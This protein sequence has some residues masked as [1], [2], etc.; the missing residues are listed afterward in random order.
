LL[1]VPEPEPEDE[2]EETHEPLPEQ[3]LAY[4]TPGP[5][6][7]LPT[8]IPSEPVVAPTNELVATL[9][10]AAS[11]PAT[12]DE[13]PTPVEEPVE[14]DLVVVSTPTP[15]PL[16]VVAHSATA[17][18]GRG[19]ARKGARRRSSGGSW[20]ILMAVTAFLIL[21]GGAWF[22]YQATLPDVPDVIT[23]ERYRSIG[24]PPAKF[25]APSSGAIADEVREPV[26]TSL[27]SEGLP[28]KSG[29]VEVWL[30][31]EGDE[32]VVEVSPGPRS[33]VVRVPLGELA[34]IRSTLSRE[35][36]HIASIKSRELRR[37]TADFFRDYAEYLKEGTAVSRFP[38]YRDDV[39]LN[40]ATGVTGY[41]VEAVVGSTPFL[42][43]Y[44]DSTGGCYFFP[45][46][47]TQKFRIRGRKLADGTTPLPIEIDV[48]V[49]NAEGATPSVEE[50]V[51]EQASPEDS[52]S[53]ASDKADAA[54]VKGNEAKEP[55][56]RDE[57][58]MSPDSET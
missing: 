38:E 42:C 28:L 20:S 37:S 51:P 33:N 35:R 1:L 39:A 16:P 47:E 52:E 19:A 23:G 14:E 45:P 8:A 21:A 49:K 55:A 54:A 7:E 10:N 27:A 57:A 53:E 12:P 58:P 56:M 41:A 43:V 46:K 11:L 9:T 6:V 44:E 17:R 24:L 15:T 18:A 29:F 36:D 3:P 4:A 34:S 26:M 30:N 13:P 31:A 2:P 50:Q 22:A 5:S 25:A 48:I 32:L 40:A